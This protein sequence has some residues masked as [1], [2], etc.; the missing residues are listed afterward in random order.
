M[1][2]E[3]RFGTIGGLMMA[4]FQSLFGLPPSMN[5]ALEKIGAWVADY[6]RNGGWLDLSS[7]DNDLSPMQPWFNCIHIPYS[8][9]EDEVF[10]NLSSSRKYKVV[11]SYKFISRSFP[12]PTYWVGI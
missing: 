3:S 8:Q 12:P 7:A 11:D 1:V 2:L 9:G 10:L 4:P 6:I 5:Y